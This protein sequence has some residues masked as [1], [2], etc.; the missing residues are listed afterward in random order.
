VSDEQE[1]SIREAEERRRAEAEERAAREREL[2]E[3]QKSIHG[4]D[5][6]RRRPEDSDDE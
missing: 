5:D 2:R 3:A 1:R 4:S 6:P